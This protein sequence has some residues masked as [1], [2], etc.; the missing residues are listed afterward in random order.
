VLAVVA[1]TSG[2]LGIRPRS[3][4]LLVTVAA[5]GAMTVMGLSAP[6]RATGLGWEPAA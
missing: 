5:D 3:V 6:L 2:F 4:A 1:R